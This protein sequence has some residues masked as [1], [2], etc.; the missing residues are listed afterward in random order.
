MNSGPVEVD[1]TTNKLKDKH[2][3]YHPRLGHSSKSTQYDILGYVDKDTEK[4]YASW[5]LDKD[6]N[7][8]KVATSLQNV[9]I[10]DGLYDI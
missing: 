6:K 9:D 4:L 1:K 3:G 10:Y 8:A 7:K 5:K 2:T